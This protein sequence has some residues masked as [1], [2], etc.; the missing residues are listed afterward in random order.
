M[1]V[2]MAL[3]DEEDLVEWEDEEEDHAR[4][5]IPVGR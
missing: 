3:N 1:F 5:E 4:W 2:Q